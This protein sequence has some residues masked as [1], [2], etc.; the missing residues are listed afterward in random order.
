MLHI[1]VKGH[2]HNAVSGIFLIFLN[3]IF[4]KPNQSRHLSGHIDILM[5]FPDDTN[6]KYMGKGLLVYLIT[7]YMY[8]HT[9]NSIS[10]SRTDQLI[11]QNH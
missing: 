10:Q 11:P 9:K 3:N 8:V 7:V 1:E 6:S 5:T 4:S 2:R